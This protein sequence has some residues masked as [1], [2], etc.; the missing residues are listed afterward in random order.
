VNTPT[1]PVDE[2]VLR[3]VDVGLRRDEARILDGITWEVRPDERWV[4]L[5][6]NGCGKT[7]LLRIAALRLHPSTG[8]VEV[9]GQQLGRTDVRTLRTRIAFSS[10]A[11]ADSL[12]P[13]LSA[14]DVVMTARRG[15][16]EP[17][18]HTYDDEDRALARARLA[19]VGCRG[20]E[21][22]AFGTLSSGERQRVLLAR[23]LVTDP[24]L[25]LLDEPAAGLDLGG[26][27]EL[28]T[29]LGD[30][31]KDRAVAPTVL[32]T[33]HL[34]EVPPGF[35]HVLLL[36]A[37]GTVAAG[38]IDDVLTSAAVSATF[39]LTVDVARSGDRWTARV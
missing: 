15:A 2:P 12:R 3:L 23:C 33:H 16:L 5:G 8:T 39:G 9:L 6:P 24:G 38:A 35:T 28:V 29:T 30:L 22:R 21:Q 27:E 18:W 25:L 32:V 34:E 37:G 13:A 14:G 20:F 4:V 11:L 19:D 31:A 36:R 1:A 7:T 17:W 10:A 26:R